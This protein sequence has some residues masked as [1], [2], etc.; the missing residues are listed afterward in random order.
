MGRR[1]QQ[2]EIFSIH[3]ADPKVKLPSFSIIA[4]ERL[5]EEAPFFVGLGATPFTAIQ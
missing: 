5:W 2:L 3:G 4:G 1:R